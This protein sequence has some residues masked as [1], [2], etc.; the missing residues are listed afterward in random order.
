MMDMWLLEA[1][2]SSGG[3]ISGLYYLHRKQ[4]GFLQDILAA[5]RAAF[6]TPL[7]PIISTG[8]HGV[9]T[10]YSY[11]RQGGVLDSDLTS[12]LTLFTLSFLH[13]LRIGK[14]R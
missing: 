10:R 1:E 4:T 7:S 5:V 6:S 12:Y 3:G 8:L 13:I 11:G 9:L 2:A 14:R